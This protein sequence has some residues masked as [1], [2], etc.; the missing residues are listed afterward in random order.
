[1]WWS[2]VP[3][4][5]TAAAAMF[6]FMPSWWHREYGISFGE[7]VFS[8]P[9][10]RA[11][12]ARDMHRLAFER[13][14]EAGLGDPEPKLTYINDD[15]GNATMPA[16]FG[17]EVV[18]A[19]DKYPACLQLSER[20][21]EDMSLPEDLT[22]TYPFCEIMRQAEH[23]NEERDAG[24][25]PWWPTMGVQNIALQTAGANFFAEYY[26]NPTRARRLLELSCQLMVTSLDYFVSA[27]SQPDEFWNQNCTVPLSGPRIYRDY[28]LAHEREL[29][30]AAAERG[31]GFAIH[32]CGCFDEYALLYRRIEKVTMVEIGWGSDLRVALDT[33][34]EARVQYIISQ[35]FVREG[36]PQR[37][38]E[39]MRSLVEAAGADVRQ[40]SFNVC[41]LEHGTP[42]DN[43]RAVVEGLL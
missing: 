15:L 33:F 20:E 29:Y 41:D 17:C 1:M 7:R 38:R 25:R 13:F 36:P 37:I 11:S 3:K 32:H 10:Y 6:N 12:L 31:V 14:G 21:I 30:N 5:P 24:L 42:D 4:M 8:D 9:E 16:A 27:G 35:Q 26:A 2:T 18:F 34:P 40:L 39:H 28:L 43:V 23:V 19:D 22:G